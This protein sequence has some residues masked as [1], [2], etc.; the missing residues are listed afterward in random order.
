VRD[1]VHVAD[2]VRHLR[3]AMRLVEA[4]PQ[5]AVLNVCTGRGTSILELAHLLGRIVGREPEFEYLPPRA[6][7]IRISLGDP[8]RARALLGVAATMSLAD[9]LARMLAADAQAA[10]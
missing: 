8:G 3:A 10:A 6:G 4:A 2:A 5:E 1:F 9:G 7:D